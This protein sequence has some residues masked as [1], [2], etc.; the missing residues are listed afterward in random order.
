LNCNPGAE[1]GKGTPPT[2]EPSFGFRNEVDEKE[3]QSILWASVDSLSWV[4]RGATTG[5]DE[6]VLTGVFG[7]GSVSR[8]PDEAA[9]LRSTAEASLENFI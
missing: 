4:D 3:P 6:A 5:F 9:T 7:R 2:S 8:Q 1:S